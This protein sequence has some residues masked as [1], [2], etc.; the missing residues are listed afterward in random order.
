MT[1]LDTNLVEVLT[2]SNT[3][4]KKDKGTTNTAIAVARLKDKQLNLV[5]NALSFDELVRVQK[6]VK[7]ALDS[8]KA[9][10][11]KDLE[12]KLQDIKNI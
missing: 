7:T 10:V 2:E 9:D 12:K 11:I 1:E 8:K 5:F 6:S 4:K 3:N